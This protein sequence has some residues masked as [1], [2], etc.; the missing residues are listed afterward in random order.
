[1]AYL[2]ICTFDLKNATYQDYLDA[3]SDLERIGLKK[4]IIS[5]SGGQVVAP[6]TT[7]AGEFTGSSASTIRD[8]VRDQVR[9][10]FLARRFSS[11]IFV[12]ISGD[13][14]WGAAST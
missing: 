4:V 10:A 9:Q 13:W 1:L 7:T 8:D 14:A 3:Y 2:A 6:T 12:V 5:E 11:E